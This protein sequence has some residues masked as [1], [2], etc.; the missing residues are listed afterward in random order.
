MLAATQYACSSDSIIQRLA[1]AQYAC[2]FTVCLQLQHL[3]LCGAVRP[4]RYQSVPFF[5]H[6]IPFNSLSVL[7]LTVA[8]LLPCCCCCH[9]CLIRSGTSSLPLPTRRPL[10]C[11]S[12]RWGCRAHQQQQDC[13]R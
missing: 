9:A 8:C 6:P 12:S 10:L 11:C 13:W 1:A 2:N 5:S 4:D 7:S 3:P